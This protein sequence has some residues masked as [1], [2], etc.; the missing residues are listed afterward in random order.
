MRSPKLI[1]A[2]VIPITSL[3]LIKQIKYIGR[4]QRMLSKIIAGTSLLTIYKS[5]LYDDSGIRKI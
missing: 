2:S 1:L 3:N 4:Q 5:F